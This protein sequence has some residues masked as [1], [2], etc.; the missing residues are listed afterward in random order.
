MQ[1]SSRRRARRGPP[2]SM[3]FFGM[4]EN[5]LYARQ[6]NGVV[7][8]L[9]DPLGDEIPV[10]FPYEGSEPLSYNFNRPAYFQ[11][12]RDAIEKVQHSGRDPRPNTRPTGFEIEA[13]HAASAS[14]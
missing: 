7:V 2:P 9:F 5:E 4:D 10:P 1:A 12:V 14:L 11:L 6:L 3:Y 8:P 13:A